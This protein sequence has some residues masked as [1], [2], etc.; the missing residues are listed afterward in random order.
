MPLHGVN[1]IDYG[2]LYGMKRTAVG[3]LRS[4]VQHR[5]RAVIVAPDIPLD[6][7]VAL[8]MLKELASDEKPDLII[9]TSMGGPH[10]ERSTR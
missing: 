9:G 4:V 6:P 10:S 7:L 3:I 8:P 5:G 1:G 2:I